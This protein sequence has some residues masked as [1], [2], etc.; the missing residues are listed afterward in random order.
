MCPD[1]SRSYAQQTATSVQ[2]IQS[3]ATFKVPVIRCQVIVST[4]VTRCGFDSLTYGQKW[5]NWDKNIMID[6]D[7]C[8]QMLKTEVYR[9]KDWSHPI[10]AGE[11]TTFVK[12]VEGEVQD[13]GTCSGASFTMD[14]TQYTNAYAQNTYKVKVSHEVGTV[15]T[16]TN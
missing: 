4:S 8:R 2:V 14:G 6:V 11:T 16:A 10:R 1:F 15:S 5:V 13:S 3:H 12:T 9:E 7:Q